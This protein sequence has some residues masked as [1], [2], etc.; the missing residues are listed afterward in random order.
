MELLHHQQTSIA[1][2]YLLQLSKQV[3]A[4]NKLAI[5]DRQ[6]SLTQEFSRVLQEQFK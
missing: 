2:E 4:L 6:G 1:P 5:L 3:D